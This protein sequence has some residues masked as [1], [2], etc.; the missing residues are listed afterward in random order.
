MVSRSRLLLL[1]VVFSCKID[2]QTYAV[3]FKDKGA[4][5]FS[6][7]RPS[8]FVAKPLFQRRM[9][10]G[11]G[12]FDA[13]IP[14]S[15]TYSNAIKAFDVRY[16]NSS[17]WLNCAVF[18]C[19]NLLTVDSIRAL[20]FVEKVVC[21]Y[22]PQR[23]LKKQSNKFEVLETLKA[24]DLPYSEY[25]RAT[26]QNEMIRV[27]FLHKM[28]F[29]ADSV[30]IAVFDVGF[31]NVN[32]MVGFKPLFD[33]NRIV[34]TYD[35]VD[36]ETNVYNDGTHGTSCLS[37]MAANEPGKFVGTAPN[38]LYGLFRTEDDN[39]E[40]LLEEYN[41][42]FAAEFAESGG[43]EVFSTS[44]GYTDFDDPSTSHTYADLDG[45]TTVITKGT[46]LA[47]RGGIIVVTSAGNEGDKSW[48]YISAPADADSALAIGAVNKDRAVARFSSRGPNSVGRVKPDVCAMGEGPVVYDPSGNIY[49]SNGT[50]FSCPILA[51]G[52]ACLRQAFP[53]KSNFE[54]MDAIR[55]SAHLFKAPNDSFG[56]GIPDLAIAFMILGN[57]E[58]QPNKAFEQL[59]ISPNP[60]TDE[61]T[62]YFASLKINKL[63]ASFYDLQGK[64]LLSKEVDFTLNS[65]QAFSLSTTTL[66]QGTY[67]LRLEG[68]GFY[69]LRRVLKK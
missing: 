65:H 7:N 51:G 33:E 56:Y 28:G 29:K 49:Q 35:I 43:A 18:D 59:N 20:P 53:T 13:D 14:V 48:H 11:I 6:I 8:E 58:A 55:A 39:S 68:D 46:N 44:L 25:G 64:F 3:Y 26:T 67:L 52:A 19:K 63:K 16:H 45:N 69:D 32:N 23:V 54:I 61:L 60:F 22:Q 10:L 21:I 38:A 34:G 2:A 1:F 12:F 9:K 5:Q 17:R 37:C 57:Q 24:E 66:A 27:D 50:S 47:A 4:T 40:T 30:R 36:Q 42:V 31:S 62:F 15:T 41:W